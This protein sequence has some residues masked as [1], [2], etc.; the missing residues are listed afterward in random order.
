MLTHIYI[1]DFALIREI[2]MELDCGLNILSG[3]TGTGK[4]IVIQAVSMAL[5]GRASSALVPETADRSVVQLVFSLDKEETAQVE[6]LGYEVEDGQLIIMR[7]LHRSGRS[8][9][10]VNRRI[11]TLSAL[12]ELTA[13]LADIHGQY[14]N[15]VFLNPEQHIHILDSFGGATIASLKEELAEEFEIYQKGRRELALLR[16]NRGE[17]LRRQDFLRFEI[18][19]ID[20]AAVRPGEDLELEEEIPLLQNSEKIFDILSRT[21]EILNT[22]QLENCRA[23]V[24]EISSYSKDLDDIS[25]ALNDCV[26]TLS[27][28]AETVRRQRDAIPLE[29]GA[30]D[31]AVSR[32]D[33]LDRLK[34][35]YGGSLEE[36]LR[37]RKR[38]EEELSSAEL[39]EERE[40]QLI[41]E[42]KERQLLLEERS[43]ELS[44]LRKETGNRLTETMTR[45]LKELNFA[46]A[47]FQV[48]YE[49]NLST[50]TGRP[51]F[52]REGTDR[53]EFLFNANRGGRLKPLAQIA[54]GGEISRISLAFRK[55]TS[56][57]DHIP[58]LIFDEI[59]T[60]IS[61]VTASVVGRKMKEI[62]V[63]R[64]ILCITHLPQIAAAGDTQFLIEKSDLDDG[65]V[66]T[67]RKLDENGRIHEVARLL[68]GDTVTETTLASAEEL[69]ATS[70]RRG[71]GNADTGN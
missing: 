32:L 44:R 55:L 35:K 38:C 23:Q 50:A 66:T 22:G 39:S 68:G 46:N 59:D 20:R 45:E 56:D 26:F 53:I 64:Q 28:L 2:D 36:V 24:E 15:Q 11:V 1:K 51:V 21:Y 70:R 47:E 27:D 6:S 17:F 54:S 41:G 43:E 57:S 65:S 10:R 49:Q 33:L 71:G 4:S 8:T 52:S 60:G 31:R 16:K 3:E 42:L 58:T 14:D 37:Y 7:E 9:A 67:I 40:Q 19:E 30:I 48:H 5:G 62:G 18:E 12:K 63:E 29:E 69:L 61:G 13:H 34:L 25:K